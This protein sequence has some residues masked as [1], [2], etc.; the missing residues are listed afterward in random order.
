M[1]ADDDRRSG[2]DQDW[3]D[4]EREGMPA[5]EDQP[6]GIYAATAIEGESP[7][8]DHPTAVDEHGVTAAEE[9]RPESVE[10]RAARER[11]D[12]PQVAPRDPAG[13]LAV[14]ADDTEDDV[15]GG[16]WVQ[17]EDGL[18]AEEAAVHVTER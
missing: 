12:V 10:E 9:A 16:E 8:A 3:T 4:A 17:D 13:R 11:P 18:S 2:R 7:P 6:P 15:A 1:N 14:G 5:T